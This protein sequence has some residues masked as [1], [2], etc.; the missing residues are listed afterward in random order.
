MRAG[1]QSTTRR[2]NGQTMIVSA[3][4]EATRLVSA[5]DPFHTF[6]SACKLP[7]RL[8][9]CLARQL[10]YGGP[11]PIDYKPGRRERGAFSGSC[12]ASGM[13]GNGR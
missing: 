11:Q 10:T 6:A 5:F 1:V 12:L 3:A 4:N 7:V 9:G 13:G 8:T 2:S